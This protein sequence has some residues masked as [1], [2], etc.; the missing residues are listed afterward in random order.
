M[1]RPENNSRCISHQTRIQFASL[2]AMEKR[3]VDVT[4][5]MKRPVVEAITA[6]GEVIYDETHLAH[7][8]SRVEGTV[9]RVDKQVG[10]AV[11]KGEVLAL[12]D[13]AEIGKAKSEF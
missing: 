12:V 2:E 8:S 6:N 7:M 5:A 11:K 9:W 3:G 1:P 13:A 4:V 10:D